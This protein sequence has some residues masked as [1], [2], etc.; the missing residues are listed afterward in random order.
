MSEA[1]DE[2]EPGFELDDDDELA[3]ADDADDWDETAGDDDD[4]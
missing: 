4:E 2:A 1:W 3:L